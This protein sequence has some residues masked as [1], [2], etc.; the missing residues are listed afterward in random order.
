MLP[1]G[2]ILH[3]ESFQYKI[4]KV[5]G[6]GTFGI[7]YQATMYT[8]TKSDDGMV[9]G[10]LD[11]AIKEFFMEDLNGREGTSVTDSSDG[12]MFSEYLQKFEKEAK[13]LRYM[14]HPNIIRVFDYFRA[15]NT[16][17][18]AMELMRSGS[19]DNMI[20]KR[21]KL[22]EKK[23]LELIQEVGMALSYM[24]DYKMLHLD[25]KPG[26]IMIND[27]GEAVLIDFGLSKVYNVNDEPETSTTV[28]KG[29]P[30]YAPIEQAEYR[31]GNDFPQTMD[32]YALGATL[33]KMLTGHKPPV[34]SEILNDGFP[35]YELQAEKISESTIYAISMAMKPRKKERLQDVGAFLKLCLPKPN[36]AKADQLEHDADIAYESQNYEEAL[37]LYKKCFGEDNTRGWVAYRIADMYF[38]GR[39]TPTDDIQ[40]APWYLKAAKLGDVEAQK[41]LGE[42]YSQGCGVPVNYQLAIKWYREAAKNGNI[43]AQCGLADML[44]EGQGV[45]Q[46]FL[47]AARWY[48]E[49]AKPGPKI[50][51]PRAIFSIGYM[52]EFGQGVKQDYK[53]AA[54][55]YSMIAEEYENQKPWTLHTALNIHDCMFRLGTLYHFGNGVSK[56]LKVA[57]KWYLCAAKYEHPIA[58]Y[59]LGCMYYEGEGVSQDNNKAFEYFEKSANEDYGKAQYNLGAC[60]ELGIGTDIDL[61]R[62]KT[63]YEKAMQQGHESA[64]E[65]YDRIMMR[66]QEELPESFFKKVKSWFQ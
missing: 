12:K 56:N 35:A 41:N 29:T 19:L 18:Y 61:E 32:V 26:N 31:E 5:L 36:S 42:I 59:N 20:S 28:G 30:G 6:H 14:I 1:E 53:K 55:W 22:Q 39:G 63:W 45:P 49:S 33:F 65:A 37:S 60:F 11:I 24:H 62:A 57:L 27:E 46:D 15:N 50:G 54:K 25:L 23:A 4:Q 2:A 40:A 43:N 13:N 17:Y 47:E 66:E 10:T 3:G 8:R 21:G 48:E 58:L 44:Y 38:M 64:R 16:A 52:Y 34:A 9:D 7:T 51:N